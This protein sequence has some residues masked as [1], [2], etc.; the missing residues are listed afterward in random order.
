MRKGSRIVSWA[1]SVV[2]LG[3]MWACGGFFIGQ[4]TPTFSGTA[5]R[6]AL[7]AVYDLGIPPTV[8]PTAVH[9]TA[10]HPAP[11]TLTPAGSPSN[12]P[13]PTSPPAPTATVDAAPPPTAQPT[14][15]SRPSLR[16]GPQ[17]VAPALAQPVLIDGDLSDWPA[18]WP[19][20]EI[21]QVTYGHAFYEGPQDLSGRLWVAWDP[22]YLYLAWDV[23]DDVFVQTQHGAWLYRGDSVEILVD[24]NLAYDFYNRYLDFDDYQIGFSPG[25][26]PGQGTEAWLWYP[27]SLAGPVLGA[28]VA[29]QPTDQGYTVEVALP[30]HRLNLVPMPGLDVGF[31]ASISD[32]DLP[33]RAVQQTLA[34]TS[35]FRHLTDPTTWGELLLVA[36]SGD[37]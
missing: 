14:L 24:T 33:G 4:A 18:A 9:S 16:P 6:A 1:I 37:G 22:D 28:R 35:P 3:L 27:Q 8:T 13:Q 29:A 15:T 23:T 32:N 19:E 17:L 21:N 20:Y 34:S 7:D 31:A 26:P 2:F 10:A 11:L 12:A 25:Q 36:R 5:S 30:W